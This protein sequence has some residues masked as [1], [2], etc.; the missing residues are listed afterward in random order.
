M[1]VE[2]S[3]V[4][5]PSQEAFKL[6]DLEERLLEAY[7]LMPKNHKA[8]MVRWLEDFTALPAGDRTDVKMLQIAVDLAPDFELGK[9]KIDSLKAQLDEALNKE[10]ANG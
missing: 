4:K 10:V 9:E 6:S 3:T 1:A 7:L 2:N 8:H 5:A